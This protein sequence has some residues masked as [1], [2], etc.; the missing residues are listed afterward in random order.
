MSSAWDCCAPRSTARRRRGAQHR[1]TAPCGTRSARAWR[2]GA[3]LLRRGMRPADAGA[4]VV[5]SPPESRRVW[6]RP[7]RR[8][9]K[10]AV[11]ML[12]VEFR[13][14]EVVRGI[15]MEQRG[16]VLELPPPGP[17]LVHAPAVGAD[18]VGDAVVIGL[19]QPADTAEA[20]G[21]E[22]EDAWSPG[23]RLDVLNRCD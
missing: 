20:G 1:R 19:E 4:F 15:G 5:A 2:D 6:L 13:G 17:Q 10:A 3:D 18:A 14:S 7:E 8:A 9:R 22:V 23:Q 16:Q 11:R 21:L 12:K